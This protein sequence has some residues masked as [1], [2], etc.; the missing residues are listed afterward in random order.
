MTW[1]RKI[2]GFFVLI[3]LVLCMVVPIETRAAVMRSGK[4]VTR[5]GEV[6][7]LLDRNYSGATKLTKRWWISD[8]NA[9]VVRQMLL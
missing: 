3:S 4:W 8:G 9:Y 7:S 2:M 6:F 5:V 1:K